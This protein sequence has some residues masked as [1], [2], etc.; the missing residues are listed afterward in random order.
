MSSS[1]AAQHS[2]A[3]R[4]CFTQHWTILLISSDFAPLL[5]FDQAARTYS[6]YGTSYFE[7]LSNEL[8]FTYELQ[9]LDLSLSD[10]TNASSFTRLATAASAIPQTAEAAT[11]V[12][13]DLSVAPESY[14]QAVTINSVAFGPTVF[15]VRSHLTCCLPS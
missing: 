9:S 8:G 10:L 5:S 11:L 3:Y 14:E 7:A 12:I 6:G 1:V 13:S 2:V 4:C 15:Q